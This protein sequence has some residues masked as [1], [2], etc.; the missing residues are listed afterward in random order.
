[1]ENGLVC[2]PSASATPEEIDADQFYSVPEVDEL[3]ESDSELSA[4][5]SES[6]AELW[7]SAVI[8]DYWDDASV[9]R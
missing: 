3:P 4:D 9:P 8:S 1:M 5:K 6:D 2:E 7:M